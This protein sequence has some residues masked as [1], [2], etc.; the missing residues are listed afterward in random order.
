MLKSALTLAAQTHD[1][2]AQHEPPDITVPAMH[3]SAR[4]TAARTLR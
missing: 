2:G 1:F 4:V 3:A